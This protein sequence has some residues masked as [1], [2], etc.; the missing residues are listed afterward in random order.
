M[1]ITDGSLDKMH[2]ANVTFLFKDF[3][4][5]FQTIFLFLTHFSPVSPLVFDVFTG[6]RNV[7]LD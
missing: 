2:E 6:Y 1:F 3:R 7:T 5:F 4:Y